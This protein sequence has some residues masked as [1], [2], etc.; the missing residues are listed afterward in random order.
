MKFKKALPFIIMAFVIIFD[1]AT[2]IAIINN[3]AIP[4]DNP[5]C[6]SNGGYLDCVEY[7]KNKLY[8]LNVIGDYGRFVFVE[9]T[10]AV[11]GIMRDVGSPI[12]KIIITLIALIVISIF[13]RYIKNDQFL[14]KACFGAIIG[15]GIGNLI[16]R[17]FG[18][19]L[20]WGNFKFIYGRV[21]DFIDTGINEQWRWGI[22]NVADAAG[23]IAVV[24]IIIY[25]IIYR[26]D[27]IF[28]SKKDEK[29]S[30]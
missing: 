24:I 9:N 29:N 21:I 25:M 23:V 19:I 18:D 6:Q 16:D 7:N 1:Q 14:V 8:K 11:F 27:N 22:Y 10:G 20:Y 15:G 12:V 5:Y 2:K 13:Y 3:F 4:P 17:I 26:K 28:I 30:N